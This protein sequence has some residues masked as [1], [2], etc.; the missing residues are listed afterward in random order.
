MS[1]NRIKVLF[2]TEPTAFQIFGGAEIQMLKTK[3]YLE[4]TSSHV[5]VKFF[6]MFNDKLDDYDILHCFHLRSECLSLCK[7]A[8]EMG[9]K[10]VLS[11]IYWPEHRKRLSLKEILDKPMLLYSNLK[12]FK[13]FTLKNLY[14]HKEFLETAD[15]VIPTSMIEAKLLSGRFKI[16]PRKFLP[17]PVGVE[18][19][20]SEAKPDL[21]VNKYKIKDFVLFVGRIERTK[22]VLTLLKACR[23]LK[24][25][26]VL[27]GHFNPWQ[28]DYYMECK[29][30]MEQS[31][32]IRFLGFMPQ[33]SRELVSAYTAAKV[34]V[35]PSWH[36]IPSLSALEAALAGCNVVITKNGSTKEYFRDYALYVDP[37]SQD[38]LKAKI[39]EAYRS[40][41]DGKLKQHILGNFTWER[42]AKETLDAYRLALNKN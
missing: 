16:N 1:K 36:E 3:E 40:P 20:F 31:H 39:L 24:I 10:V 6:D 29:K 7:L 32:N 13:T 17:V 4:R 5:K 35:L 15:V 34:F 18:K 33:Y 42:T 2:Y 8:K 19:I 26:T 11:T 28:H 37:A 21:F 27:I 38:D 9:L 30:I 23:D 14:P 12:N 25:Q 22:N 41:K